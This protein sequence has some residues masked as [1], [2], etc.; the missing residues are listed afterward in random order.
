M[1]DAW[2]VVKQEQRTIALPEGGFGSGIR[3]TFRTAGGS[4][5][6]IDVPEAEYSADHVRDLIDAAASETDAITNL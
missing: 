6:W 4:L 5:R 3:V 2:V 1:A